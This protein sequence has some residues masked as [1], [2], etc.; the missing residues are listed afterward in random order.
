GAPD[1]YKQMIVESSIEDII[2]TDA[3]SGVNANY[4]IPSIVKAG[5]DPNQLE[6]KQEINF[7][8]LDNPEV[9]AWKDV[10]GSGQGIGAIDKVQSIERIVS[11]LEESYTK[12]TRNIVSQDN[13]MTQT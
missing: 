13:T 1:A 2:Y 5:L 9:K 6:K 7:E 4:L 10:W 12:A 11:E 8:K 3:F